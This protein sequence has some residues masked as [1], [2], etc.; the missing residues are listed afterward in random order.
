[1]FLTVLEQSKVEPT[2]GRYQPP[3]LSGSPQRQT[4]D[5]GGDE[6]YNDDSADDDD[7]D[8]KR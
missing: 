6:G 4:S 7:D 2:P 5:A 1:M 3:V 8:V